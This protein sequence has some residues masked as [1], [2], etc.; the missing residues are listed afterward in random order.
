MGQVHQGHIQ[1]ISADHMFQN[2]GISL[3]DGNFDV[4]IGAV[5]QGDHLGQHIGADVGGGANLQA[6][7]VQGADVAKLLFKVPVI[8]EHLSGHLDIALPGKG[9][10]ETGGPADEERGSQ[11]AFQAGEKEA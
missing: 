4:G 5:E 10:D 9:G 3:R 2:L 7:H 1:F 11:L 8:L 6:A